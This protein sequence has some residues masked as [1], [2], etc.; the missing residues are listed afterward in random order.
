M[1]ALACHSF[2]N[3]KV[4]TI[5]S[6][7]LRCLCGF[8]FESMEVLAAGI[9]ART[10]VVIGVSHSRKNGWRTI[11]LAGHG[12]RAAGIV[13]T[14]PVTFRED[15]QGHNGMVVNIRGGGRW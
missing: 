12:I 9:A 7:A 13:R 14:W 6:R 10:C 8:G 11:S 4:S 5:V 15:C 2:G 1:G 3:V